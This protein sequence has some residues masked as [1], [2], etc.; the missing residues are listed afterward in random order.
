MVRYMIENKW[1][2]ASLISYYDKIHG[3]ILLKIYGSYE[4]TPLNEGVIQ[5]ESINEQIRCVIA[6]TMQIEIMKQKDITYT[7]LY[8]VID[9][10]KVIEICNNSIKSTGFQISKI[11]YQID[12]VSNNETP[13]QQTSQV[14]ND[15]NQIINQKNTSKGINK[16]VLLI[17]LIIVFAIVG[18]ITM[19][20]TEKKPV[21][22]QQEQTTKEDVFEGKVGLVDMNLRDTEGNIIAN[23]KIQVDYT[24]E[25]IDKDYYNIEL[26]RKSDES[27]ISLINTKIK[28]HVL[29]TYLLFEREEKNLTKENLQEKI[30]AYD[31]KEPINNKAK[32]DGIKINSISLKVIFE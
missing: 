1:G 5:N 4:A 3:N 11:T 19:H 14:I 26:I 29:S 30:N 7:D 6:N 22:E 16:K 18:F 12:V 9:I 13:V 20:N 32:D 2:L 21:K 28:G 15:Q 27:E 25:I 10:N 24:Y 31:F 8:N 23:Y 17:P